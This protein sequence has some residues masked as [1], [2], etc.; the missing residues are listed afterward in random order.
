LIFDRIWAAQFPAVHPM[1]SVY[2][3]CHIPGPGRVSVRIVK[4]D[5]G[6]LMD[7]EPVEV[8]READLSGTYT[9]AAIEFPVDGDYM[10][11]L[12]YNDKEIMASSL[13]V[14]KRD[15]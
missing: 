4:P 5:G 14:Q 12:R 7:L 1:L 9:L 15:K 3:K 8:A 2:W 13:K 6:H 10:V 11:V